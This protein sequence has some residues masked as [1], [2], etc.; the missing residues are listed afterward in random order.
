M[1]DFEFTHPRGTAGKFTSKANTAP[2]ALVEPKG[3]GLTLS[4]QPSGDEPGLREITAAEYDQREMI[5]AFDVEPGDVMLWESISDERG[6]VFWAEPV[7]RVDRGYDL[8]FKR[9]AT[10]ETARAFG[11]TAIELRGTWQVAIAPRAAH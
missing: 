11:R 4:P 10:V 9:V 5:D 1:T 8:S 6:E 2:A 7:T 3:F